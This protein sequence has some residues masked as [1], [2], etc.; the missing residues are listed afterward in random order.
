MNLYF[1]QCKKGEFGRALKQHFEAFNVGVDEGKGKEILRSLDWLNEILDTNIS[2][3]GIKSILDINTYSSQEIID[4]VEKEISKLEKRE[5]LCDINISDFIRSNYRSLK[6]FYEPYHPAGML[7]KEK[8]KR[9]LKSIGVNNTGLNVAVEEMDSK[10]LPVYA[11]VI[12]ALNLQ[13]D[14]NYIR[15]STGNP[16]NIEEYVQHYIAWEVEPVREREYVP[17]K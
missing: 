6:L 8:V 12:K 7:I 15:K 11:S 16:M 14:C 4:N 2:V 9:I 17:D 3:G 10:E 1:P 5:E 13:F